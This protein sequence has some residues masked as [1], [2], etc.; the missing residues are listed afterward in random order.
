M[1]S[2][3]SIQGILG[4]KR[5]LHL[6]RRSTMGFSKQDVETFANLNIEEAF[7]ALTENIT[8]PGLPLDLN[9]G[10]PW[11]L[12]SQNIPN[13]NLMEITL[14]WIA[15]NWVN[16][17]ASLHERMVF[18]W[19]THF[20]TIQS[21][22]TKSDFLIAQ[23]LLFRQFALGNYKQ[24]TKLMC[25]DNAML[26]H[27]DNRLNF[28][29]S[30][31]ENFAREF[32]ELFTVGK[33]TQVSADDYT[34]F[35]ETDVK[36]A[37]RLLTGWNIDN[38][39]STML[40][41][42]NI[43]GGR[44]RQNANGIAIHHDPGPKQFSQAFNGTM[45]QPN[46]LQGGMATVDAVYQ[47]LDDFIDMVF[48]SEATA[49]NFARKLYRFFV[50]HKITDEVES[51]IIEPLAQVL[52]S[53]NYEVRFALKTLL[54]S[55]H[56]FDED[57]TPE[58][59]NVKGT[60]IKSPVELVSGTWAMFGLEFP[61]LDSMHLLTIF[62]QSM[63]SFM[64]KC[65]MPFYE[66]YDVAGFDAYFQFPMFNRS[67]ITPNYLAERYNLFNSIFYPGNAYGMHIDVLEWVKNNIS[68]PGNADVLIDEVTELLFAEEISD[69]RR[70]FF[71]ETVLLD[72][73]SDDNWLNEWDYY[74]GSND[75]TNVRIQVER[76]FKALTQSPEFQLI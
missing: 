11:Y 74:L 53:N 19:H 20:P 15:R 71:K 14:Y 17:R 47:E 75:D 54:S 1:P 68:N 10:E 61:E 28:A 2:L 35:T 52:K 55:E 44:L 40:P 21:R 7:E 65:G 49:I 62:G 5:A 34:N 66:P 64:E 6:L 43:P 60:I 22:I 59:T 27:L 18:Y 37:T 56:F 73:L 51:D 45:I 50:Y 58:Q 26:I 8:E 32:L 36:E 23:Q 42:T 41:G 9:T 39:L 33:G 12:G 57:S 16:N 63:S 48:E 13:E 4:K 29:S 30:P 24:L 76:L 38:T 25:I 70:I 46:Q 72:G 67:W 3:N 31:Q 69:S